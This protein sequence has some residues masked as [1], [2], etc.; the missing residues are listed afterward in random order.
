[1]A[2]KGDGVV[3]STLHSRDRISIFS[4]PIKKFSSEFEMT[5]EEKSVVDTAI[6][7][8]NPSKK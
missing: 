2:Q 3:M 4:K 5:K 6:K 7:N 8:I 1:M